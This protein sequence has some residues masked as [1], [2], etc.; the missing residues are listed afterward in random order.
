RPAGSQ[1]IGA[2]RSVLEVRTVTGGPGELQEEQDDTRTATIDRILRS[3]GRGFFGMIGIGKPADPG[4]LRHLCAADPLRRLFGGGEKTVR[5][6]RRH[7]RRG[8][9]AVE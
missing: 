1:V 3:N 9:A 8:S 4:F 2:A 6:R 5:V 7:R